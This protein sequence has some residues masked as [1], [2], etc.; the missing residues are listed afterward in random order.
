MD[1]IIPISVVVLAKNEADILDDCLSTLHWADEIV[2]IDDQSVD[3]TAEV[4]ADY[5]ARVI[6]HPFESFAKQRNWALRHAGLRNDWVLMLDADEASTLEFANAIECA[7]QEAG[8][9]TV[10]FRTCRRT[11]LGNRWLRFS[12]GYP[13]WIMR[14]VRKGHAE[15]ADQ[16]HGEIPVPA[17]G[18]KMGTIDRPFIHRPFSRGMGHWWSRHIRYAE[19]EAW[20]ESQLETN[21][22]LGQL[23]STDASRRRLALRSLSRKLPFRATFRFVYQYLIKGGFRDGIAGLQYCRM[24][25]CY[26]Q[27]IVINKSHL[28]RAV[29][30]VLAD[31]RVFVPPP[32]TSRKRS[33][34]RKNVAMAVARR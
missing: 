2:V 4:A 22:K 17:V 11:M 31:S 23:L 28:R 1:R 20:H 30:P 19:R 3:R 5:D 34:E 16:G 10:A 6:A 33:A 25:A 14:L 12:D 18:G 7:I 32:R 29:Q 13:V 26:E 27:M 15:F 24:M 8:S 21:A 9:E